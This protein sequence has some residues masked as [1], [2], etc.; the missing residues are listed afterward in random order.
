MHNILLYAYSLFF[1]P[2]PNWWTVGWVLNQSISNNSTMHMFGPKSSHKGGLYFSFSFIN[3][4]YWSIVDLQCCVSFR[5]TAK[6]FIFLYICVCICMYVYIFFFRL[7]SLIGYYKI[8]S[9]F[10]VLYSRSLLVI[11]FIYSSMYMLKGVIIFVK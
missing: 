4:F 6:W 5:Y 9:M 11:Y 7:L 2:I 1:Y 8:L 3:F 10:P